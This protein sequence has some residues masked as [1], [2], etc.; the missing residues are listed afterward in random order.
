MFIGASLGA[1]CLALALVL[2]SAQAHQALELMFVRQEALRRRSRRTTLQ[3]RGLQRIGKGSSSLHM[4]ILPYVS[5]K[6]LGGTSVGPISLSGA[7]LGT[8]RFEVDQDG[9]ITEAEFKCN[10]DTEEAGW[11]EG[12]ARGPLFQ[13]ETPGD[14][15]SIFGIGF[16]VLRRTPWD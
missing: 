5:M 14:Q 4:V 2:S 13:E 10:P 16:G 15:R 9:F 7:F 8:D 1:S 6:G 11:A 3:C 12:I